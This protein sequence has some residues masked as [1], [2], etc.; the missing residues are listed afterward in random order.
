MLSL[1]SRISAKE[2]ASALGVDVASIQL[3]CVVQTDNGWLALVPI[4][5][6]FDSP[7]MV[8][9]SLRQPS[10]DLR[11]WWK[12]ITGGMK[13]WPSTGWMVAAELSP[14]S[15]IWLGGASCYSWSE[16]AD[17]K[18]LT[19]HMALETRIPHGL[20]SQLRGGDPWTDCGSGLNLE[21][22]FD[23]PASQRLQLIVKEVQGDVFLQR[24][25]GEIFG[26]QF[27]EERSVFFVMPEGMNS[28]TYQ[29]A[30]CS[31]ASS[32]P[33]TDIQRIDMHCPCCGIEIGAFLPELHMS[34]EF[35]FFVLSWLLD[36]NELPA[37]W[38]KSPSHVITWMETDTL[39]GV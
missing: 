32:A 2:L 29:Y 1:H 17:K 24:W 9:V 3:D 19:G 16:Q 8:N 36:H 23:T 38:N 12:K 28:T 13:Q 37:S 6:F 27:D 22:S 25:E 33:E 30:A 18:V 34:R 7:E 21:G 26:L 10:P 5:G 35:G 11:P 39:A 15:W 14:D 31:E 20:F 4:N